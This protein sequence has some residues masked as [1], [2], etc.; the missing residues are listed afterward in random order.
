VPGKVANDAAGGDVEHAHAQVV[1]RHLTNVKFRYY[2]EY[3]CCVVIFIPKL[4]VTLIFSVYTRI[5][6]YYTRVRN[7][8][9]YY[10]EEEVI[11]VEGEVRDGR[12]ERHGVHATCLSINPG[13]NYYTSSVK[14]T[15]QGSN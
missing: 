13:A 2:Y 1:T 3:N 7:Y 8:Y 12:P 10:R 6:D 11:A 5:K 15:T 14:I 4:H 9:G